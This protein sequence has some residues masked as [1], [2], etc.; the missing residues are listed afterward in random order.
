MSEKKHPLAGGCWGDTAPVAASA[1]CTPVLSYKCRPISLIKEPYFTRDDLTNSPGKGD[2]SDAP[3][4]RAELRPYGV[5]NDNGTDGLSS[6]ARK[7][8]KVFRVSS[9]VANTFSA[10]NVNRRP[11]LGGDSQKDVLVY[12]F[13]SV[14]PPSRTG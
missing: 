9:P 3:G 13:I 6:F 12:Q 8:G 5:F 2:I 4:C 7:K 14:S 10:G 1:P 11:G